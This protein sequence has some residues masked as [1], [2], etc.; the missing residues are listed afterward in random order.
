MS[1]EGTSWRTG[2]PSFHRLRRDIDRWKCLAFEFSL[3]SVPVNHQ[4]MTDGGRKSFLGGYRFLNSPG[5]FRGWSA[6]SFGDRIHDFETIPRDNGRALFAWSAH[7]AHDPGDNN[8]TNVNYPLRGVDL[9]EGGNKVNNARDMSSGSAQ[10]PVKGEPFR[11]G[12][13]ARAKSTTA[14]QKKKEEK[15]KR[16]EN[17]GQFRRW[18]RFMDR[19]LRARDYDAR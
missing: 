18:L 3:S 7:R 6:N 8:V 16:G 12:V 2:R 11:T 1:M 13:L 9:N 4:I 14:W 5:R 10:Y 15:E 19:R 17:C